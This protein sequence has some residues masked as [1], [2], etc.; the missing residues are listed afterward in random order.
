MT[1]LSKLGIAAYFRVGRMGFSR[2]LMST[3]LT[4]PPLRGHA[5]SHPY[6][7]LLLETSEVPAATAVFVIAGILVV[8]SI[9]I[10]A[11]SWMMSDFSLPLLCQL[12]LASA[13]TFDISLWDEHRQWNALPVSLLLMGFWHCEWPCWIF[14]SL[15]LL[16]YMIMMASFLL[17]T[18]FALLVAIYLGLFSWRNI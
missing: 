6:C 1:A 17:F 11:A 9:L 7:R 5:C 15:Q 3:V 13:F 16:A 14:E 12:L 8:A 10:E 18:F 2:D 4:P